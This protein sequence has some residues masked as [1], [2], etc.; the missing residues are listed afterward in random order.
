M[1]AIDPDFAVVIY[2]PEVNKNLPSRFIVGDNKSL[3]VP[4]GS[5]WQIS[6]TAIIIHTERTFN[7]PVMREI[8]RMPLRVIQSGLF[9]SVN[10]TFMEFPVE[11][12]I[13]I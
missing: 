4:S 13:L 10:I 3:S 12:K 11:V 1:I 6:G 9:T 2:T 5:A 8:N 7:A